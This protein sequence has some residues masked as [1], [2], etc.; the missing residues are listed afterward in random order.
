MPP[1]KNKLPPRKKRIAP[2]KVARPKMTL[3]KR[4][5]A[6][7]LKDQ[8]QKVKVYQIFNDQSPVGVGLNNAVTKGLLCGNA[9]GN[10]FFSM[11]QGTNQQQRIGNE[12]HDCKLQLKGFIH[13]LPTVNPSNV[14]AFPFE[15]HV[16]VYKNKNDPLGNPDEILQDGNNAN[17][18]INGD[19]SSTLLPWNRKGYTIKKHR[20][21][22][23]KAN[24]IIAV[25]TLANAIGVENPTYNG[26]NAQFFS[27]FN[28]DVP[29]KDKLLF[30]D[31][32]LFPNNDW[33]AI[34][35]YVVNG[36]GT[37]LDRTQIRTKL[38]CSA[39]LRYK[40]A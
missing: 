25:S 32:G 28:F 18:P 14:S 36:D 38:S 35:V 21:F 24:P 5:Q 40:D 6:I 8:E 30:D 16:L 1:L 22:R 4:I 39:T 12:I 7:T 29:I 10:A 17:I 2:R 13:S 11:Q 31:A 37:T 3:E 23:M 9:L 15:V 33:F 19:D 20:V 34:G 27:R 26:P